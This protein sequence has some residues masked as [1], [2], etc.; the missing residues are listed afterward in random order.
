[1]MEKDSVRNLRKADEG[2]DTVSATVGADKA[3]KLACTIITSI[4]VMILSNSTFDCLTFLV[5][6]FIIIIPTNFTNTHEY[7]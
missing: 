3:L 7:L 6:S 4:M 5:I 2:A 1:M